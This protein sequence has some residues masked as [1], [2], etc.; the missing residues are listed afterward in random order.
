[1]ENNGQEY[2]KKLKKQNRVLIIVL[3]VSICI[4]MLPI[5]DGIQYNNYVN[6]NDYYKPVC[7][8]TQELEDFNS[9][10]TNYGGRQTGMKLRKMCNE[11]I[12]NA[13]DY[14]N[15][16]H[17]IVKIVYKFKDNEIIANIMEER[18]K[19]KE[20]AKNEIYTEKNF[21]K[22]IFDID[23]F[24]YGKYKRNLKD[25]RYRLI[26]DRIDKETITDNEFEKYISAVTKIKD[27]LIAKHTY[28]VEFTYNEG[29]LDIITISE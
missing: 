19:E 15:D 1:M 10:Y 8:N 3:I 14:R 13:N 25:G 11:V 23:N 20:K 9:K 7:R 27:N 24:I 29:L 18:E 6:S 2:L 17:K 28:E 12:T 5:I 16:S 26:A 21:I 22:N 4:V